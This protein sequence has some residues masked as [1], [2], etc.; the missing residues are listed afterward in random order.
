MYCSKPSIPKIYGLNR[1]D[2][3]K[4]LNYYESVIESN[5]KLKPKLKLRRSI[6]IAN[7]IQ[8]KQRINK[9]I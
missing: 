4:N 8:K 3:I 9:N 5:N 7:N 2:I 1:K 6:R